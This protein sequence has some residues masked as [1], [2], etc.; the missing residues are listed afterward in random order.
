MRVPEGSNM[1]RFIQLFK[2]VG[3]VTLLRQ[4]LQAH[5]ILFA[6]VQTLLNGFSKK[7]LEIVRL[8]VNHRILCR[9]RRKYRKFIGDFKRDHRP[10]TR[11]RSNKVW[12]CW[13]QGMDSAPWLVQRCYDSLKENLPDR[14]IILLT[15]ENYR[16]YVTFPEHIT[17]K[18]EA[19][20]I[21]KAQFSDLLRLELLIRYGGTWIDSTVF[22]SG[23]NIPAYMLDSDLFMFQNLKPGLD[24]H[25]TAVSN[26]LITS[27]TAHPLLL[28][29]Q[30]LLYE[31]W[32]RHNTL[33]DYFIFHDFF[34]LAVETY[35]EEWAKVVPFSNSTP[36]ILLLRLFDAY[37]A[38][39]WDAVREMTPFHK[40]THKFAQ[41]DTLVEGT[42]YRRLFAPEQ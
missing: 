24:G 40:L 12:V 34:Q 6:M 3:G 10:G 27:C 17:K 1:K 23:K 2:K 31:Y 42:Y 20:I 25:P 9:L 16:Q 11:Q 21:P 37:D 29:T 35:P 4:Y 15:E 39:I 19:G 8:A 32:S 38:K 26:W 18:A 7:S 36:H 41:A 28:L 33:V 22:C 30:A 13:F 5:V 14:E